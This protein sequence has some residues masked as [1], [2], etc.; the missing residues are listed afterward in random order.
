MSRSR[1]RSLLALGV[2]F[3]ATAFAAAPASAQVGASGCD[4]PESS[5]VFA[6][7]LDYT[8]YFLA[9]DGGFENG[10]AGWSLDG[11]SVGAGNQSYGSGESSLTVGGGDSATSPEVCVGLEHP[12]FRFFVRRSSGAV[13]ALRVSVVL[14]NGVAVPVG[15]TSAS[16][17]WQPSSVML[18]GA[19]L[20]PLVT[21][22]SSTQVRFR[23][24]AVAGTYQVDDVY[25]D[26]R[27]NW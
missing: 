19:N 10:G 24:S 5:Q 2:A 11:A 22:D 12:T 17:S 20:L 14:P 15:V 4:N 1:S 7:W 6:Q 13:A 25:V 9:P 23:F 3:V 21:G 16:A 26:P 8:N 18:V 27:G